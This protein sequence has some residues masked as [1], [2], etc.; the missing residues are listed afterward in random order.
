MNQATRAAREVYVLVL[1]DRNRELVGRVGAGAI[2]SRYGE[3]IGAMIEAVEIDGG[4]GGLFWEVYAVHGCESLYPS[5]VGYLATFD[6]VKDVLAYAT[7]AGAQI[8]L[9]TQEWYNANYEELTA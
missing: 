7:I 6:T 4:P 9:L 2:M 5:D 8:H 3:G 1:E